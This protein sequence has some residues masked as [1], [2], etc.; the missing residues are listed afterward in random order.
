MENDLINKQRL[1]E[2]KDKFDM[3][4]LIPRILDEVGV[5]KH[6]A[7]TSNLSLQ[8][9]IDNMITYYIFDLVKKNSEM[10]EIYRDYLFNMSKLEFKCGE[11][12]FKQFYG[13]FPDKLGLVDK[14]VTSGDPS[15]REENMRARLRELNINEENI[16]SEDIDTIEANLNGVFSNIV[17]QIRADMEKSKTSMAT[18]NL[19]NNWIS[20]GKNGSLIYNGKMDYRY[21]D[22]YYLDPDK[23]AES[24][25]T[26]VIQ[27]ENSKLIV[28]QN[29]SYL[30][31]GFHNEIMDVITSDVTKYDE[32]DVEMERNVDG[33]RIEGE[34]KKI[35]SL[36]CKRDSK[37]PFIMTQSYDYEDRVYNKRYKEYDR[38]EKQ[39]NDEKIYGIINTKVDDYW[40]GQ[41]ILPCIS[42]YSLDM[43]EIDRFS[44]KIEFDLS[45]SSSFEISGKDNLEEFYNSNKESILKMIKSSQNT[46]YSNLYEKVLNGPLKE[47]LENLSKENNTE[48]KSTSELGKE[49]I[50]E[51]K[52]VEAKENIIA[53]FFKKNLSKDK[54][55]R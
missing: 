31:K 22:N 13:N 21:L 8:R 26:I 23:N 10:S 45:P 49:T 32:N 55:N 18:T 34:N 38:I 24:V 46:E 40:F 17:G 2:T 50:A 27:E 48:L 3:Q 6:I 53:K 15:L 14:Y 1:K 52:D 44:G 9:K 19:H 16:V 30:R 42:I 54:E 12:T 29:Y 47:D 7:Y 25:G 28:N 41:Q 4:N 39:G 43:P 11:L 20:I 5:N 37:Y 33:Y 36:N 35:Y 51:Q